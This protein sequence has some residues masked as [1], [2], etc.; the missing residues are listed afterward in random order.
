[1]AENDR[2]PD[3]SR[4]KRKKRHVLWPAQAA[5]VDEEADRTG[6]KI[7]QEKHNPETPK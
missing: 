4:Q 2:G 3:N 1:M 5:K 6:H 7:C